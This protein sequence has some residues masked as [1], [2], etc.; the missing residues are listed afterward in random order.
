MFTIITFAYYKLELLKKTI[1]SFVEQSY[2][3]IEIIIVD[4]GSFNDVKQYLKLLKKKDKRIKIIELEKN[5]FSFDDPELVTQYCGSLAL[6]EAKGKYILFQSYDDPISNDYIQKM[7]NLYE[8]NPK[9]MSAAGL[10]VSID[11]DDNINYSEINDRESNFRK[12]YMSGRKLAKICIIGKNKFFRAPGTIFSFRTDFFKK[13]GGFKNKAIEIS[14]LYGMVPFGE[15]GFDETAYSFWRR[16]P[17]QL[18][19]KTDSLFWSPIIIH[20]DFVL[21]SSFFEDWKTLSFQDAIFM[22]K[23]LL[24]LVTMTH[25]R[26]TLQSLFALNLK[27]FLYNLKLLL[28]YKKYLNKILILKYTKKVIS[29]RLKEFLAR[30]IKNKKLKNFLNKYIR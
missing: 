14:H 7:V 25:V 23:K 12:K 22:K 30:F 18:H 1:N 26:V 27:K 29:V 8:E 17:G 9:C 28:K 15:T 16:H 19:H 13:Y 20:M 21:K 10:P 4:N 11:S 6:N 2:H 24:D 5:V 3:N